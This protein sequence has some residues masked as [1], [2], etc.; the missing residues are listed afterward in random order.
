MAQESTKSKIRGILFNEGTFI[1]AIVTAASG[2][3]FWVTN[4][5]R[6]M[7]LQITRL[8]TQVENAETVTAALER[9]KANDLNEIQLQIERIETRQIDL[10]KAV[11]RLEAL[12]DEHSK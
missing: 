7:Q 10:L 2:V 11:A 9:I 1:L 3:I 6:D 5:Q 4:P 8:Q 12:L